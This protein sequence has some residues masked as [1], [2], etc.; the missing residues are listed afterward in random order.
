MIPDLAQKLDF[1][2]H[3]ANA[4]RA[5]IEALCRG[6]VTYGFHSAF[7]N[8][9]YVPM[10]KKLIGDKASVG[11]VVSFPLGQ[12]SLAVKI[13]AAGEAIAAGADELDIVPNFASFLE[14]RDGQYLSE[15]KELV[16]AIRQR[17][18]NTI[19][20]FI[21]D[22]GFLLNDPSVL[23]AEELTH[24]ESLVRKAALLIRDSGADF[25]KV[26]SGWGPRGASVRDITVVREAVGTTIKVKAAGGIDTYQEAVA[27]IEAGCDRLGTSHAVEIIQAVPQA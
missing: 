27:L 3:R 11:T 15:M 19:V 23:S 25:V 14:G 2:N 16:S 7:V 21:I 26:G 13:Q 1:A 6:V 17:K 5:D 18:P 22:T 20:K 8:P 9:V 4:T 24:A 10:A 12:D